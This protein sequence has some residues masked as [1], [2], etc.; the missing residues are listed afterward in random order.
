MVALHRLPSRL[1]SVVLV[2]ITPSTTS[3]MRLPFALGACRATSLPLAAY[4]G[5]GGH[6]SSS[7]STSAT[8]AVSFTTQEIARLRHLPTA[9]VEPLTAQGITRFQ[10]LLDASFSSPSTVLLSILSILIPLF[11]KSELN[12]PSILDCVASFHMTH[13]SS[14][15]S[16]IQTSRFSYSCSY[17]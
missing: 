8:S 3:D 13:D 5:G 16:S 14:S 17:Y 2:H 4:T 7:D 1:S 15:L 10:C 9:S 12:F 6:F 11:T